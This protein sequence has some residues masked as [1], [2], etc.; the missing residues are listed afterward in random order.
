MAKQQKRDLPTCPK[1]GSTNVMQDE[2]DIGV[3]TM[4]GPLGC[5]DCGYDEVEEAR[6]AE[7]VPDDV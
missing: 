4:R 6:L 1:C 7:R 5:L 2:V 3:G